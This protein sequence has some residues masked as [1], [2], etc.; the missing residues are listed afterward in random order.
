MSKL[1]FSKIILYDDFDKNY[2]HLSN[3]NAI[4]YNNILNN[5]FELEKANN[6]FNSKV[7]TVDQPS[8]YIRTSE[9]LYSLENYKSFEK[10]LILLI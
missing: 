7:F 5:N 10:N 1:G 9:N 2:H 4:Y 6:Q 3:E 8:K